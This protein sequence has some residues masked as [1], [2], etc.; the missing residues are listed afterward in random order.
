MVFPTYC[1]GCPKKERFN[2]AKTDPKY[3][4]VPAKFYPK[5]RVVPAG[6][7]GLLRAI[8]DL[9][10][11][12]KHSMAD[13]NVIDDDPD[14]HNYTYQSVRCVREF[15]ENQIQSYK[16][17]DFGKKSTIAAIAKKEQKE[18]I[19]EIISNV[20]ED[21]SEDSS[22][23]KSFFGKEVDLNVI[24]NKKVKNIDFNCW[25]FLKENFILFDKQYEE[26]IK[27]FFFK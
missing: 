4:I 25:I 5:E 7:E 9:D 13:Y 27:N 3:L 14:Y 2:T 23:E 11:T 15:I 20:K 18:F 26:I 12:M 8:V 1:D 16:I 19:K 22:A 17:I 6:D 21:S 10:T 24:L